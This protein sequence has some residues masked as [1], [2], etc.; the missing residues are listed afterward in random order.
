MRP[1]LWT[2]KYKKKLKNCGKGAA[3]SSNGW[4]IANATCVQCDLRAAASSL[5]QMTET[6][7]PGSKMFK[8]M[9]TYP[10]GS[11]NP[12]KHTTRRYPAGKGAADARPRLVCNIA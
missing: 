1:I 7:P 2:R 6:G 9:G 5:F 11:N 8:M 10:E 4:Q 12:T 3:A